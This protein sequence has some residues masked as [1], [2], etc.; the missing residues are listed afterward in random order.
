M[1]VGDDERRINYEWPYLHY[2]INLKIRILRDSQL[3][4]VDH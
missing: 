4:N 3:K 1:W 2:W